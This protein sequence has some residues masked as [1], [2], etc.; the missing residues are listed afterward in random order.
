M[1]PYAAAGGLNPAFNNFLRA[2]IDEDG[3]GALLS[4]LS[5]LARLDIDPWQE[6]ANLS[7]LPRE[8]ATQRL[9]LLIAG[10]PYTASICRNPVTIAARLIALL[11]RSVR[12]AAPPQEDSPEASATIRFR[13]AALVIFFLMMLAMAIA[14]QYVP[15]IQSSARTA[16][17]QVAPPTTGPALASSPKPKS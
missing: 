3:N 10:L 1:I 9:A 5:A 6:A 12:V 14:P 2:P 7:A 16:K 4:V 17:G 8:K 11:P 15:G 13:K